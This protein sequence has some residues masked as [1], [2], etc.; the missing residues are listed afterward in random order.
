[1]KALIKNVSYSPFLQEEIKALKRYNISECEKA[2][3]SDSDYMYIIELNACEDL[4]EL[5]KIFQ[6]KL[7]IDF[8]DDENDMKLTIYDDYIE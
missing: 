6:N 2:F 1:M 3:E 7:V 8:G 4:I 5:L